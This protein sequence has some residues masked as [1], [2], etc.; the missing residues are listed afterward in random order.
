[1]MRP[2]RRYYNWPFYGRHTINGAI[3]T[4]IFFA[5][6]AAILLAIYW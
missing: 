5:V 4:V 1:M 2:R 6:Y 3:Q